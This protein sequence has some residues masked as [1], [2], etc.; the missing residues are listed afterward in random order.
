MPK[1][2]TVV[3]I[4]S[5]KEARPKA[6]KPSS[7]FSLCCVVVRINRVKNGC[8]NSF[9]YAFVHRSYIKISTH[10]EVEGRF[11]RMKYIFS[12]SNPAHSVDAG[13]LHDLP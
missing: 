2:A 11:N 5:I 1:R 3:S 4:E 6:Q 8:P 10:R 12:L 7:P 9:G 13:Q